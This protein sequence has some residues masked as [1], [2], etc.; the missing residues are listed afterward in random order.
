[1][2]GEAGGHSEARSL[3]PYE[4]HRKAETNKR[5]PLALMTYHNSVLGQLA[6][7]IL[8]ATVQCTSK[9]VVTFDLFVSNV[10]LGTKNGAMKFNLL[11]FKFKQI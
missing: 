11:N 1:M 9:R 3:L 4:T 7:F 8:T 10:I 6:E 2:Y 5:F